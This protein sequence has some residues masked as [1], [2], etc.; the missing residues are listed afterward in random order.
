MKLGKVRKPKQGQLGKILIAFVHRG[1][2]CRK[3]CPLTVSSTA[4][5]EVRL[6]TKPLYG[7][8][9]QQ[10]AKRRKQPI[11][12]T[13]QKTGI[14]KIEL[15]SLETVHLQTIA[16]KLKQ[17]FLGST[18]LLLGLKAELGDTVKVWA[19][20]ELLQNEEYI[21]FMKTKKA[22]EDMKN[23]GASDSKVRFYEKM[24][25]LYRIDLS[26]RLE[27]ELGKVDSTLESVL[28]E[29]KNFNA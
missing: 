18:S 22:L 14:S 7:G 3:L 13:A 6:H 17:D 2:I 10:F 27:L 19:N 5:K 28:G 24:I 11:W 20:T 23:N 16:E 4:Q 12:S 29:L 8:Q 15:R 26:A 1:V 25:L 21:E 9:F